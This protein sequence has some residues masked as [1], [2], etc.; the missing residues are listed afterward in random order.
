MNTLL[1]IGVVASATV[2]VLHSW[3]GERYILIRLFRRDDLPRLFGSDLFTRR[4]IRFAWHL[5]SVAWWGFAALM[6]QYAR[7]PVLD[8]TSLSS[9]AIIR[10]TFAVSAA[11][12]FVASRG[13]HLSWVLF[14]TVAV[15]LWV[16]GR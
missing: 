15:A 3:L 8:P 12:A 5:T 10:W 16:A 2:G 6:L 9:I 13:R 11:Y 7:Q 1:L 4:T 14:A